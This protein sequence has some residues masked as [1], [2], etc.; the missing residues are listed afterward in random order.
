MIKGLILAKKTNAF[1]TSQIIPEE[2]V[3]PLIP[4]IYVAGL[5]ELVD[6]GRCQKNKT[7]NNHL[8]VA[9]GRQHIPCN[10]RKTD[11]HRLA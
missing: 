1:T 7:H 6:R 5:L 3:A 10:H 11:R 9:E 2:N 8:C 4:G